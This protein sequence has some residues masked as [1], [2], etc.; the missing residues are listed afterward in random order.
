[1]QKPRMTL[2][3]LHHAFRDAGVGCNPETLALGIQQGVFPFAVAIKC[4]GEYAYLIWRKKVFEY[5][6]ENAGGIEA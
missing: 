1:M 4:K 5:L 3:E 6:A 2:N